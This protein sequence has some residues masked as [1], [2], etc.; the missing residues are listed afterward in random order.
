MSDVYL[1]KPRKT[2]I[3]AEAEFWIF[4]IGD[5]L[6]FSVFFVVF[7]YNR[8]LNIELFDAAQLQLS[9]VYGL[10]NAVVLLTSSWFVARGLSAARLNRTDKAKRFYVFAFLC[11]LVFCIIKAIEYSEKFNSNIDISNN[12]FYQYYFA[13]TGVHLLHVIVGLICLSVM[14]KRCHDKATLQEDDVLFL[15]GG[16]VYWHMVDILWIFLF[17][18][19]YLIKY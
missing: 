11:G 12:I 9:Q 2:H 10:S 15:E 1:E 5:M 6:I 17:F 18:V 3:P 14:I 13:L 16:G 19:I 8:A 4:I 7:M